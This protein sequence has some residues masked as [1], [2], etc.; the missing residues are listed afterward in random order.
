MVAR[1]GLIGMSPQIITDIETA[2]LEY[3]KNSKTGTKKE[4]FLD[5]LSLINNIVNCK[6]TEKIP[7]YVSIDDKKVPSHV[8]MLQFNF[9]II[10][11]KLHHIETTLNNSTNKASNESL[12]SQNNANMF[13][14]YN[15]NQ[16]LNKTNIKT[17]E[18]PP[19]SS[20]SSNLNKL[21]WADAV[22]SLPR[23]PQPT[24]PWHSAGGRNANID[25]FEQEMVNSGQFTVVGQSKNKANTVKQQI[26]KIIGKKITE[27]C[28]L[29]AEKLLVNKTVY[30][31]SNVQNRC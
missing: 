26:K 20:N 15:E 3:L 1:C 4:K 16:L 31:M 19:P 25:V 18:P 27:N 24:P 17:G 2:K 30:S 8:V 9:N 5:I 6:K 13:D 21:H 22:R 29:K 12:H 11:S 28:K 14:K 23:T 10:F 7:C